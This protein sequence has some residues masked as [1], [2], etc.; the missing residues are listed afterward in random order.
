MSADQH[1]PRW[2]NMMHRCYDPTNHHYVNYGARGVVVH[3]SWH[4]PRVYIE[5]LN[6]AL[7]PRPV[8]YSLDR[9]DNDGN[10]EPGNLRWAPPLVQRHNQRRAR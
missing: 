10:Y 7:G 1:Y 5:Y 9:V 4:D 6:S 8:G 3:A 2:N